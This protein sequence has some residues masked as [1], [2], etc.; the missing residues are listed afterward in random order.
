MIRQNCGIA[1][2]DPPAD[3]V[4]KVRASLREVGLD[5]DAGATCLLHLLGEREGTQALAGQSPEA[6]KSRTFALLREMARRGSRRHPLIILVEDLQW[7]DALSEEYAATL[8]ERAA[9]APLLLVF[10][11]RPGHCPRWADGSHG[12][13]LAL[14]HLT[15]DESRGVVQAVLG[16]RALDE[17]AAERSLARGEG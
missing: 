14:P 2:T 16:G 11:S 6:I 4:A 9:G 8:V 3:I 5:A 1:E 10:T 7:I 12:T 17:R 15:P 13:Q